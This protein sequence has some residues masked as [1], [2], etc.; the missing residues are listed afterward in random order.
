M[1]LRKIANSDAE[2]LREI[3]TT[4]KIKTCLFYDILCHFLIFIM[5]EEFRLQNLSKGW[6]VER[7]G[8]VVYVLVIFEYTYNTKCLLSKV[9]VHLQVFCCIF[10]VYFTFIQ[11]VH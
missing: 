7:S 1:F 2:A 6:N 9:L 4:V 3:Y 8:K 5:Y 11:V 10:R